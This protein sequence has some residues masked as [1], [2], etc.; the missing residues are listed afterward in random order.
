M[1]RSATHNRSARLAS[2]IASA[3]ARSL[4]SHAPGRS[5][6]AR[7]AAASSGSSLL[8]AL[9]DRHIG[10]VVDPV[11]AGAQLGRLR[12]PLAADHQ[13][14]LLGALLKLLSLL[15]QVG[16]VRLECRQSWPCLL[17]LLAH[18]LRQDRLGDRAG[19]SGARARALADLRGAV[20][21]QLR[22]DVPEAVA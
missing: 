6:A 17:L 22:R 3:F 12:A 11:R 10:A 15:D 19:G 14:L 1:S 13:H 5:S 21:E 20:D 9:G 8:D 4:L 2:V 16:G 18:V 7:A